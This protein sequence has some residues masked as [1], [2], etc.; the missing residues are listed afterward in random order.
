MPGNTQAPQVPV[1]TQNLIQRVVREILRRIDRLAESDVLAVACDREWGCEK[2]WYVVRLEKGIYGGY[3]WRDPEHPVDERARLVLWRYQIEELKDESAIRQVE[4]AAKQT[5]EY[6]IMTEEARKLGVEPPEPAVKAL[7]VRFRA[8]RLVE[9]KS[10]D[11]YIVY[12]VEPL[13]EDVA[14]TAARLHYDL[15]Y[16]RRGKCRSGSHRNLCGREETLARMLVSRGVDADPVRGVLVPVDSSQLEA[17]VARAL[18]PET[19]ETET[20]GETGDEEAG[21]SAP[22]PADITAVTAQ[23]LEVE[24]EAEPARRPSP[25]AAPP[26][27]ELV[28]V[29]MLAMHLPTEDV[30]ASHYTESDASGARRVKEWSGDRARVARAIENLR[31]NAYRRIERLWCMIKDFGVWIT[32]SEEGIKEA[33]RLNAEVREALQKLGL[34]ELARRYYVRA[35]RVYLEPHDAKML[36]DAAVAQMRGEIEE[37]EKR[38]KEAESEQ[39]RRLVRELSRKREYVSAL[40]E[41]FRKYLESLA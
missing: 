32:V 27:Q 6:K 34:G 2:G 40:L 19:P 37:L 9:K 29:Y 16:S 38:I 23:E 20:E 7:A 26:R 15:R 18:Q 28:P 3:L 35:V 25:Q 4:D 13:P 31:R 12:D 11:R 39:N 36:L 30:V 33:E 24:L 41:T 14:V 17:L 21:A 22:A 8:A 10:T 1:Q 5:Q